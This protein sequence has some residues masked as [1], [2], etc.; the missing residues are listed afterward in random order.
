MD[1]AAQRTA[2]TI[3]RIQEIESLIR[4]SIELTNSNDL[5]KLAALQE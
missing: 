1:K 3:P 5:D 4:R 2:T